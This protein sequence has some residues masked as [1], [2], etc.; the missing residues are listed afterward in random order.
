MGT[1]IGGV[2]FALMLGN[3]PFFRVTRVGSQPCLFLFAVVAEL[4]LYG[5]MYLVVRRHW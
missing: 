2:G 1:I 4:I 5:V 3:R